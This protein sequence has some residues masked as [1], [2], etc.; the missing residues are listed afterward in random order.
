M[1]WTFA[2]LCAATLGI[3]TVDDAPVGFLRSSMTPRTFWRS[4][5]VRWAICGTP[6]AGRP[7]HPLLSGRTP[8]VELRHERACEQVL[9]K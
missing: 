1:P 4:F 2:R 6:D 7:E 3:T 5:H 9:V 8:G